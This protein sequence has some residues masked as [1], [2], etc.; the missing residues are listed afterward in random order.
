MTNIIFNSRSRNTSS[1]PY[2]TDCNIQFVNVNG[3]KLNVRRVIMLNSYYNI[4]TNSHLE[5]YNFDVD[6]PAGYYSGSA[7][8]SILQSLLADVIVT[9]SYQTLK[10]SF[11]YTGVNPDAG[12]SCGT[13]QR[14]LGF[15]T[16]LPPNDGNFYEA[17]D[18]AQ[19]NGTTYYTVEIENLQRNLIGMNRSNV[20]VVPNN[21]LIGETIVQEFE[22][23]DIVFMLTSNNLNNLR[24]K[25]YDDVGQLIQSKIEWLIET[26]VV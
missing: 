16:L 12:L 5:Q 13:L 21:K 2:S 19:L 14:Q 6:V 11:K 23:E 15:L 24:V 25:I 1:Y 4:P 8:A 26:I 22:K 18:I 7:L 20:F 10:L 3:Y 9:Y 17:P